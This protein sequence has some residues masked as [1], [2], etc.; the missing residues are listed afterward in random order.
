M[1]QRSATS[2]KAAKHREEKQREKGESAKE[3]HISNQR[4]HRLGLDML[5]ERE[6]N[7]GDNSVRR[8]NKEREDQMKG[9]RERKREKRKSDSFKHKGQLQA[10]I[11]SEGHFTQA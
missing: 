9:E 4:C 5:G 6:N 1:L 10:Q 8:I 11:A 3:T 7:N 2:R